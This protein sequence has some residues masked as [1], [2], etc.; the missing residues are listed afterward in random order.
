MAGGSV[1]LV[2]L[3]LAGRLSLGR[4][5]VFLGEVGTGATSNF[6]FNSGDIGVVGDFDIFEKLLLP[7]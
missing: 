4:S 6:L 2:T 3:H 7:F 1:A 5:G